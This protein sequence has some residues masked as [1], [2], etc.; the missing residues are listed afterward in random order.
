M[1][2]H[3]GWP[4]TGVVLAMIATLTLTACSGNDA[5]PPAVSTPTPTVA[6]QTSTPEPTPSI[7]WPAIGTARITTDDL[8]VRAAPSTSAVVI[9]RLNPGD[10]VPVS[11]RAA[12]RWVALTGIGWIAYVEE[13]VSLDVAYEALPEITPLA[14]GFEFAGALHPETA[15]TG[16]PVVDE[17]VGVV[18]RGD[19]DAMLRVM[20]TS[21]GADGGVDATP[22][23][24]DA[25]PDGTRAATEMP[26]YLDRFFT[27][28]V[29]GPEAPLRLYAVVGAPGGENLDPQFVAIF[30][31]E[32]G[33]GRQMWVDAAGG[34]VT[35]FSLGCGPTMP[36]EM[37]RVTSG[38]AF[39]WVRPLALPPLAPLQ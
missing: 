2:G 37:L 6:V 29:A 11:G 39:F 16:L 20:S 27:S 12:G 21:T 4:I 17:V 9:G 36:A 32:G 18:V 33:E 1:S 23:R 19:R 15:S 38:E 14:A 7:A 28:D 10:E 22:P 31:F 13:W 5:R 26:E 3:R 25:C 34:G 35:W 24:V 30:A 8:N